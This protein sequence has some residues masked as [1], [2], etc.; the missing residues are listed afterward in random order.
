VK[1]AGQELPKSPYNVYIEGKVGD[2]S[3]AYASGPGIEPTGVVVDKP[4]WFEIDVASS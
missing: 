1:Y 4:T 3:K 2:P